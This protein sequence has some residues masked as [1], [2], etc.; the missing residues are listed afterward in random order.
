[1]RIPSGTLATIAVR[2]L[3]DPSSVTTS[4]SPI[5]RRGAFG[6]RSMRSAA[7]RPIRSR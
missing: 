3:I 5:G 1:M 6:S 7:I 2:K 4:Q